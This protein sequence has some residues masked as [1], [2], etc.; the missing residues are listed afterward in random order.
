MEEKK[1]YEEPSV[2]KVEF[3]FNEAIT[4]SSCIVIVADDY[5]NGLCY[6]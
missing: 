4:A 2:T 6:D 1:E 5:G 3:E